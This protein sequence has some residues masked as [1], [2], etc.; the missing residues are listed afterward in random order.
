MARDDWFRNEHWSREIEAHFFEKLRRARDKA[1]YLK[2]QAGY[3]A[4]DEPRTALRLLEHFFDL[5]RDGFFLGDAHEI[6]AKSYLALGLTDQALISFKLALQ[7]EREFPNHKTNAWHEFVLLI[8][9]KRIKAEYDEV[10]RVLDEQREGLVF[11]ALAFAWYSASA[12]IRAEKGDLSTARVHASKAL[13]AAA[14]QHSG[15]RYHARV[16]LVGS[17][18]DPIRKRLQ[19]LIEPTILERLSTWRTQ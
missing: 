5:K 7:R 9:D 18:Y 14:K 10:L 15:F 12:L 2:I 4:E 16:G 1:Q 19:G 6:A 3:L 11:P 17:R 13:E 8:A